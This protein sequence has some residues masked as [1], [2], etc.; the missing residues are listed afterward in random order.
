[1][2]EV[3]LARSGRATRVI[4]TDGEPMEVLEIVRV[5]ASPRIESGY[6]HYVERGGIALSADHGRYFF[7]SNEIDRVEDVETGEIVLTR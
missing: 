6:K 7:Y 3:L 1:M 4:A 5:T 2:V